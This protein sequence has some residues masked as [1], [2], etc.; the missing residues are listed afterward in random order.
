MLGKHSFI[1]FDRLTNCP[2]FTVISYY[3]CHFR[4]PLYS[5]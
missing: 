1:H 5:L 2:C 3:L 4:S